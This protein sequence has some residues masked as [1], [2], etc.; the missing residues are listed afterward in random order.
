MDIENKI[1][2]QKSELDIANEK[3][4][5]H[6]D[7]VSRIRNNLTELKDYLIEK[8]GELLPAYT[9]EEVDKW[10]YVH[11]IPKDLYIYLTNISRK[12]YIHYSIILTETSFDEQQEEKDEFGNI[13]DNQINI[14]KIIETQLQISSKYEDEYVNDK[15]YLSPDNI[16]T[17]IDYSEYRYGEINVGGS[18]NNFL[19]DNIGLDYRKLY[20]DETYTPITQI[21]ASNYNFLRIMSGLQGLS[22]AT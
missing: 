10:N 1:K 3:I 9:K 7:K 2:N 18:F 19:Y 16:I 20:T 6:N 21:Y 5:K 14:N 4:I 11:L 17:R 13:S 12:I 15:Y 22:Y 8:H